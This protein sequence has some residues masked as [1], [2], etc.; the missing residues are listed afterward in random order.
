M[1]ISAFQFGDLTDEDIAKAKTHKNT[2]HFNLTDN[3]TII[4]RNTTSLKG[5]QKARSANTALNKIR[6]ISA[7]DRLRAKLEAKKAAALE[8]E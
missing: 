7:Q 2:A 1:S 6:A 3:I 8:D 4:T 5:F